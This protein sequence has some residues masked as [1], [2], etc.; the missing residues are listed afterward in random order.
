MKELLAVVSPAWDESLGSAA[1]YALSLAGH[2]VTHVTIL[3]AEIETDIVPPTVKPDNMQGC[4]VAAD[5]PTK[6]ERVALTIQL[7]RNAAK[8]ANAACTVLD[9][10]GPSLRDSLIGRAQLHDCAII[11]VQGPLRYP[12]QGLVEGVLFGSGRPLIL[13]PANASPPVKERVV[14]AWDGT[15]AA[16]RALR[17]AIP[18]LVQAQEVIVVSVAGDKEFT[19]GESG[20]QVCR[21]L[22]RWDVTPRFDLIERGDRNV[23]DALLH[24]AMQTQA[25]LLVMGGF[26]HPREREFLFGSATRD[27]FQSN[28]EIAVLLSH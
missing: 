2:M 9:G 14:V 3:V 25:R 16:V 20:P 21:Y 13:T 6:A 10:G 26:G 19:A 17:D 1:R 24:H 18:L 11:D 8:L 5:S 23:G 12:R 15:P 27:V 28:L 4:G 7:A 22:R